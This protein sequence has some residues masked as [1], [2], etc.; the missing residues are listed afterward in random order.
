M[1]SLVSVWRLQWDLGAILQQRNAEWHTYL[2]TFFRV[3]NLQ[4][5]WN[6]MDPGFKIMIN[7][8]ADKLKMLQQYTRACVNHSLSFDKFASSSDYI[9]ERV[10]QEID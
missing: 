6:E 8:G 7:Q 9:I 3:A 1:V 5:F 10:F 4:H 2:R